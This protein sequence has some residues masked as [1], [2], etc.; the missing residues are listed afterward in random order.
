MSLYD[1]IP[2]NLFSVLASKNKGL[3][4]NALYVVLDLFKTHL[5]KRTLTK[6]RWGCPEELVF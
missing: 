5:V 6:M 2:E 1:V 3:Y 4:C